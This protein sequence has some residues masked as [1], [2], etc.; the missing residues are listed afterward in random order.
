MPFAH[1]ETLLDVEAHRMIAFADAQSGLRAF[2][3]IDSLVLGP[4]AG[5]VRTQPYASEAAAL[6]D[7]AALARAMTLKLA[8]AGLD[9]G[10]AKT[11]VIDHPGLKRADVF[12]RLGEYVDEL[13]GLY[14]CAGDLGTTAADLDRM[15]ERSQYVNTGGPALGAAT[16]RGVVRCL[17]ALASVGGRDGLVGLSIAVQGTGAMGAEVAR[18]LA[19]AGARLTL[20]DIDAARVG[21]LAAELDARIV[22]PEAVLLEAVDIVVPCAAA[23]SSPRPSRA[24]CAPGACAAPPTTSSPMRRRKPC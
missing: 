21:A 18:A 2:L 4:S 5:G 16:G 23:P 8:I 1:L 13:R 15:A 9:A 19:M 22:A 6:A 11:V 14:R 7:V 20:A 24:R 12:R 17:E 10:G 3:A